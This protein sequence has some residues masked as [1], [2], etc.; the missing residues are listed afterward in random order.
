MFV[1]S[2]RSRY[3]SNRKTRKIRKPALAG[4]P[5]KKGIC[6]KVYVVPPK[7]PNSARR[8]VARVRLSNHMKPIV[9]IPGEKHNLSQ[10]SWVLIRGGRVKDLPG[11][12]YKVIRNKY[13]AQPVAV[14]SQSRSKYGVRRRAVNVVSRK[15]IHHY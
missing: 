13:D 15:R 6:L 1:Y 9:Y 10:Y 3:M 11:I 8:A 7:K 5:Q 14:R 4:S 2:K 12:R